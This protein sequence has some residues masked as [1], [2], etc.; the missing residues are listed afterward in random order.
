MKHD[1]KIISIMNNRIMPEPEGSLR[2]C[3]DR[4]LLS[5]SNCYYIITFDDE[6]LVY[7]RRLW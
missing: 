5:M 1:L 7:I 3:G 6:L 2:E 4:E